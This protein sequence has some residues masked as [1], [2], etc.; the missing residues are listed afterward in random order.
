[1]QKKKKKKKFTFSLFEGKGLE[2][3]KMRE[4]EERGGSVLI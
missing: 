3:N 4:K 1:M 2:E